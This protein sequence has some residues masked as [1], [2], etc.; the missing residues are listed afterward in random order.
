MLLLLLLCNEHRISI[1]SEQARVR[2]EERRDIRFRLQV[3][4]TVV[5][6]VNLPLRPG[7]TYVQK[8]GFVHGGS[9]CGAGVAVLLSN[10]C[11]E[12]L[13]GAAPLASSYFLVSVSLVV[14]TALSLVVLSAPTIGYPLL[15]LLL[16]QR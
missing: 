2:K 7:R 5:R 16:L 3:V 14:V 4:W 12:P 10:V 1:A 8:H 11:C 9:A 15:L 6:A 13:V